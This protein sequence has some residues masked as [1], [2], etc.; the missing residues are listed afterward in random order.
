MKKNLLSALVLLAMISCNEEKEQIDNSIIENEKVKTENVEVEKIDS[1]ELKFEDFKA[2]F[3]NST[4]K[5]KIDYNSNPVAKGYKTVITESY[6]EGKINFAGYY[7]TA[8]WGCGTGCLSGVIIDT[9]DGKVYDLPT[10][11]EWD[12][13]G[14]SYD[15]KKDSNLFVTSISGYLVGN[16]EDIEYK[17]WRWN[18]TEKKFEFIKS[19]RT[20][21]KDV[22]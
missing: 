20:K 3:D 11:G 21:Y 6:N 15:S 12:G 5:A 18:E 22:N 14:N 7:I 16:D 2:E 13:I 19:L 4:E 1:V 17:Y 9:R 8:G 10:N